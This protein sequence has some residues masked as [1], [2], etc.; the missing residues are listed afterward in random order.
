MSTH[1]DYK[2]TCMLDHSAMV[3]VQ[4]E[5]YGVFDCKPLAFIWRSFP[6]DVYNEHNTIMFDDLRCELV[7]RRRSQW[8]IATGRAPQLPHWAQPKKGPSRCPCGGVTRRWA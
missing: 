7:L 1:P 4:T 2:L 8:P 3:T 6:D 5:K